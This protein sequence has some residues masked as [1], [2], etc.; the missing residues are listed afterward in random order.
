MFLS[1]LDHS[2]RRFRRLCASHLLQGAALAAA[3]LL[4]AAE[5]AAAQETFS[6]FTAVTI[7]AGAPGTTFGVAS[8]YPSPISVDGLKKGVAHVSVTIIGFNH[9][10]PA[11]VTAL[12]VGPAGQTCVLMGRCGG[13]T[14]VSGAVI[15]L[16]D[17][18]PASL[19]AAIVGG[20]F[21]P[22]NCGT[23]NL[24]APAPAGPYGSTLSVF[25]GTNGNG[26]WRLY[27]QDFAGADSGNFVFGWQLSL[28]EAGSPVVVL[29]GSGLTI[30]DNA[31]ASLYPSNIV[32]SGLTGKI[33]G[34]GVRFNNLSHTFPRDI[35]ALLVGPN[36]Q[37]TMI[38]SD[39]GGGGP[40]ISG[41][42]LGF[43]HNAP[44][45]IDP[46]NPPADGG[47]YLPTDNDPTTDVFPAPAPVGPYV[48]DLTVFNGQNPNGTWSLYIRDDLGG[49]TGSLG[50]WDLL[51]Y[52]NER[53]AADFNQSGALEVQDI[54]DFLN[55]WFA[56]CP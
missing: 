48:A 8:P 29:H 46:G 30:V 38:M 17:D 45:G 40:G 55:A 11:D 36:G 41:F 25:N 20:T 9:T 51:I 24:D 14:D 44:T 28:T 43:T 37:K 26:V 32:V 16:D 21:R 47:T 10:F 19:P 39:C 5:H 7:P 13:S 3:A 15:T 23:G 4:G 1:L 56:G 27:V 54:F 18:A 35:D 42:N 6:N 50:G 53:C 12:L 33:S 49:D 31:A 22:T 2:V 34:V 52:Q